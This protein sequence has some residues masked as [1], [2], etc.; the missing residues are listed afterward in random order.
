MH[1]HAGQLALAG[2]SGCPIGGMLKRTEFSYT[3]K[4][5]L[6]AVAQLH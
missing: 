5:S 1:L 3:L 4:A 6:V 2:P